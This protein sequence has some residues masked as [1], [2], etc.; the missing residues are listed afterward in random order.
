MGAWKK[1]KDHEDKANQKGISF[2]S[3]AGHHLMAAGWR[4]IA[5]GEAI[6]ANPHDDIDATVNEGHE[7]QIFAQQCQAKTAYG[8]SRRH[9]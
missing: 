1:Y 3:K 8:K 5:T 2:A 6:R 7:G 4:L 9:K